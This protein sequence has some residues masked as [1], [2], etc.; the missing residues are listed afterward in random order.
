M[1]ILEIGLIYMLVGAL[2]CV[3]IFYK[4]WKD[5]PDGCEITFR[6]WN[7]FSLWDRLVM[8]NRIALKWPK[9]L[10]DDIACEVSV[11]IAEYRFDKIS[12][13]LERRKRNES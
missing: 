11:R 7:E 8:V 9:G 2:Y 4:V 3:W 6:R 13:E 12:K 1:L 5:K 10:Y